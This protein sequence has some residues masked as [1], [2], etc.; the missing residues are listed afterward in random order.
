MT[1]NYLSQTLTTRLIYRFIPRNLVW[2]RRIIFLHKAISSA[3]SNQLLSFRNHVPSKKISAT[4][5]KNSAATVRQFM[6]QHQS[7]LYSLV[8]D[9]RL[10]TIL[11]VQLKNDLNHFYFHYYKSPTH[12]TTTLGELTN[13]LVWR[14]LAKSNVN[15]LSVQNI[16][17]DSSVQQTHTESH[18]TPLN[19]LVDHNPLLHKS[20][21]GTST[22]EINPFKESTKT[23]KTD[24]FRIRDVTPVAFRFDEIQKFI[25]FQLTTIVTEVF[26]K[27]SR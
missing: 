17:A 21:D 24:S 7:L 8:Q 5:T 15:R 25:L 20:I 10:A 1:F 19:Q 3:K 11:L 2:C 6:F 23:I 16:P 27:M 13:Q 18:L 4:L 22:I 12:Y 9:V 26:C 14:T